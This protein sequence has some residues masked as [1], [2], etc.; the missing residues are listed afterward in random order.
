MQNR[1]SR[2][3]QTLVFTAFT[4]A[5]FFAG[6]SLHAQ[7]P[8]TVQQRWT[9]GGD[10]SWDYMTVDSAARRLY[11]AHQTRVQVVNLDT[12]KLV[13]AIE[14]LTRCHGIVIA[15]GGKTGFISDGGANAIV[16]FDPS[17]SHPYPL[18]F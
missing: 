18:G 1:I 8:F 4:F 5:S 15:P 13:G 6:G 12:G 17:T 7:K 9:I 11:I 14:S 10:G 3:T 16:I 2:L